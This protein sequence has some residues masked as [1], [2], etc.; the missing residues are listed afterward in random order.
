MYRFSRGSIFSLSPTFTK[1][2]TWTTP[3]VSSVAG[4]V[5]FET[6]SPFTPGSVSTT[7]SSTDEGSCTL[8]GLPFTASTCTV[9]LGCMHGSSS[10]TSACGTATCSYASQSTTS[11]SEPA[12][13]RYC[14]F[15]TSVCTRSSC[16]TTAPTCT[17]WTPSRTSSTPS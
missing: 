10:S 15:F 13:Y 1:S 11:T 8:D 3:P 16:T 17:S 2:G 14:P 5:T 4:F 6:V 7:V 12:S 9:A